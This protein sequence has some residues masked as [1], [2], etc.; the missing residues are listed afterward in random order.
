MSSER[1]LPLLVGEVSVDV[2][3]TPRGVENKLRFGGIVHAARG[4][5]ASDVAFAAAIFVPKY[6]EH[7]VVEYLEAF[8][9]KKIIVLGYVTGAPNVTLIFDPTEVDDQE[10]DTLLRGEKSIELVSEVASD[11][12]SEFS[13]AL[14]IPGTYDLVAAHNLLE[15]KTRVHIDVA[16]DVADAAAL[17][18]LSGKISTILISTSSKLF[19]QR[20]LGSLQELAAAWAVVSP[21]T[22]ILK[23]NRGGSRAYSYSSGAILEIAAQLSDSTVNS[24]GVGDVYDATYVA[25]LGSG[26]EAA[27]WRAT[28]VSSAYAQTT[29]PALFRVYARRWSTLT[30]SELKDL[31]G[32]ILPWEAR[33][34]FNIYLAAPDFKA[35]DRRDIERAISALRYHNFKVRRP[36]QENGELPP[37][38]SQSV[39]AET[40]Q[41]DLQLLRSCQLVF[42]IPTARDP[43][44]LV[45]IGLA[46]ALGI[47][48]VVYDPSGQ[49]SN[50]MVMA[51]NASYSSDLGISLNATFSVLGR[52]W[53]E[54][55]K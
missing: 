30:I 48:V 4:F 39:L 2:T 14:F 50:T 36:V 52:K 46:T 23:E 34:E 44:T 5:W 40:Y 1:P 22:L 37:N 38:S 7:S 41:K 10:Y 25:H 47:P 31:G 51:G 19:D 45:E 35:T 49:S 29:E 43:G 24:V 9:C 13:D 20:S 12:F 11:Q 6:L 26:L 32:T 28:V 53:L 8:G 3:I 18:P 55:R 27:C 16:Y 54:S 15:E 42:A 33:Q 21:Q 17:R